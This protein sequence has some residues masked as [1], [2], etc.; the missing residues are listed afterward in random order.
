MLKQITLSLMAL[1]LVSG[2]ALA[3]DKAAEKKAAPKA[4]AGILQP[5]MEPTGGWTPAGEL[6]T[7]GEVW[8][9]T[10]NGAAVDNK[11]V[12]GKPVTLTGEILDLSCYLQLGK[13]GDKHSSCGKKCLT[14][15]QPIGLVT[16]AGDVY[17]L[18]DEEHD[19]R[20]DGLTTFRAAAADNFAKVMTV[21]GTQTTVNGT[22]AVFVQ[23]F[24]KK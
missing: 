9:A 4:A 5:G 12:A 18:I 24:L 17:L 23:G 22:K 20:R 3:Q 7:K 8:T 16:K 11:P 19:P 14:A 15:G 10:T 13:H 2:L 6:G 1:G 21:T